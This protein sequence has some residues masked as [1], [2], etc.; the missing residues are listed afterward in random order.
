[1]DSSQLT[2]IRRNRTIA[3][4]PR[5][6]PFSEGMNLMVKT[7]EQ[8]YYVH[9]K[10]VESCCEEQTQQTQQ[11]PQ[12]AVIL[13]FLM[14][15]TQ[16]SIIVSGTGSIDI[17]NE[18]PITFVDADMLSISIT[19]HGQVI[20]IYSNNISYLDVSNIELTNIAFPAFG[21]PIQTLRCSDNLNLATITELNRLSTLQTLNVNNCGFTELDL[22]G[23]VSL[24]SL[25]C[26][27]NI[28]LSTL[29]GL[30]S[31]KNTLQTLT[32]R[33]CALTVIDVTGF[34]RLENISCARNTGL[35]TITGFND[36]GP[37]LQFLNVN[38]CAFTELDV[39]NFPLLST[40]ICSENTVLSTITG[41]NTVGSTLQLLIIGRCAF[42]AIDITDFTAIQTVNCQN[43]LFTQISADSVAG[44]IVNTL[45]TFPRTGTLSFLG[46]APT[47]VATG[48]LSTLRGNG[49]VVQ[50]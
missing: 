38:G 11:T 31:I 41:L 23:C 33:E 1:M 49:W 21:P 24:Q 8:S 26:A 46:N 3:N 2:Y 19:G 14:D 35:S 16:S 34:S 20:Y 47:I 28:H 45:G 29:T 30:D 9:R 44:E 43:N 17:G 10:L 48:N 50:V 32:L 39:T 40:I 5:R 4:S 7:G 27:R 22:N 6:L 25:S 18:Q 36:V 42:T 15:Q 37:T 12:P 13:T